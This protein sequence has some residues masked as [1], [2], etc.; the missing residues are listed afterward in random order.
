MYCKVCDYTA[1]GS[2]WRIEVDGVPGFRCAKCAD[3]TFRKCGRCS[4]EGPLREWKLKAGGVPGKWCEK[5][6]DEVKEDDKS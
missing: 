2:T 3:G 6:C 1:R 5:C 4:F